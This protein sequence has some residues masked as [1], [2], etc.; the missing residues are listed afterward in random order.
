MGPLEH[1]TPLAVVIWHKES[2]PMYA[3]KKIL[4][5]LDYSDTSRAALSAALQLAE[6]H[7]SELHILHV[8]DGMDQTLQSQLDNNAEDTGLGPIIEAQEEAMRE[9][10]ALER[11]RA[12][13]AGKPLSDR[14]LKLRVTGGNWV[15]VTLQI[16]ADEQ[17]DL[18]VT[19]THGPKKGPL[20][21]LLGSRSQK[22]LREATCSVWIVKPK[23]YPYLRD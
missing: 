6:D 13:E 2:H 10:V 3:A 21:R 20:G 4:V 9:A 17:L 18:V 19:A 22:L 12:A 5:P 8:V 23:G 7:D 16:I 11:E 1:G 14:P 15:D